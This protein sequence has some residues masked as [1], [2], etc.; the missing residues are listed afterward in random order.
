[1]KHSPFRGFF[2]AAV[3]CTTIL[4]VGRQAIPAHAAGVV[5]TGTPASCTEAALNAALVGGGAVTFNCG[6]NLHSITLSSQKS[7]AANT[8]IDGSG[9]I[10]LSAHGSRHFVVNAGATLA[11]T[12]MTLRDG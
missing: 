12:S 1:M 11:L 3:L 8:T 9:K 2:A 4:V 5:G 7:I 10:A 6:P